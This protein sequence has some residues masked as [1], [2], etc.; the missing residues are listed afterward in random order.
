[1]DTR[2]EEEA[3]A[4]ICPLLSTPGAA[5]KCHGAKCMAWSW[6]NDGFQYQRQ[7]RTG[8]D[9]K[10]PRDG[11]TGE[12]VDRYLAAG[13]EIFEEARVSLIASTPTEILRRPIPKGRTGSCSALEAKVIDVEINS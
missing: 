7:V 12:E 9:G 10:L 8:R 13:W 5:V 2:T 6:D 11:I 4:M 3:G 1:M